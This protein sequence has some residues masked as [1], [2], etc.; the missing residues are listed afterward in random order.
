MINLTPLSVNRYVIYCNTLFDTSIVGNYFL[1]GFLNG[2]TKEWTYVLPTIVERNNRFIS[3]DLELCPNPATQDLYGGVVY[4]DPSG[5]WDYKMWGLITPSLT[6]NGFLPSGQWQ[7]GYLL[8]KGQMYLNYQTPKEVPFLS[9]T[10]SNDNLQSYIYYSSDHI[11]NNVAVLANYVDW[12]W[13][14]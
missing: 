8:D 4:L 3:F 9:Y 13:D 1:F 6:P 12:N 11:W 10:S 5:N 14:E 7:D 2:F